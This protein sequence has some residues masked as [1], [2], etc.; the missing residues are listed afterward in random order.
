MAE[1]LAQVL[2]PDKPPVSDLSGT[3][4][5]AEHI[6]SAQR[7]FSSMGA[8]AETNGLI[9][10]PA[11]NAQMTQISQWCHE[12]TFEGHQMPIAESYPPGETFYPK[13]LL[14]TSFWRQKTPDNRIN[15]LL[16]KGVGVEIAIQGQVKNRLKRGKV[17]TIR[18]HSDFE[19]YDVK[20][21]NKADGSW[22]Q[23]SPPYTKA[24]VETLGWGESFPPQ[25]TKRM[26][27]IP[28][29]FLDKT[30]EAVDLGGVEFAV[31]ELE[32]MFVDKFISPET[33]P[34]PEGIDHLLLARTYQLDPRKIHSYIDQFYIDPHRQ[35]LETAFSDSVRRQIEAV[36][37]KLKEYRGIFDIKKATAKLN[38]EMAEFADQKFKPVSASGVTINHWLELTSDQVDDDGN[39][40]DETFEEKQ[41][42]KIR[43][44]NQ[45]EIDKL[46]EMHGEIDQILA[47]A[48]GENNY[49]FLIDTS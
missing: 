10:P 24:F 41:R 30:A 3:K 34:R 42:Q 21:N 7:L 40:I 32:F 48:E 33:R 23:G 31:P 8:H 27:T 14:A 15:Y 2:Q 16:G 6:A 29:D 26:S 38:K 37:T 17:P 13:V 39:I 47:E 9:T 45:K 5:P 35:M 46:K 19:F 18:S 44:E 11:D 36:T 1:D 22:P 12:S 28:I 25:T 4:S 43:E 20:D 49:N